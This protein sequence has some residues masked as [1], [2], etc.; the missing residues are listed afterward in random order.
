MMLGVLVVV[1]RRDHISRS[2]LGLG[3]RDITLI[4]SLRVVRSLDLWAWTT[5]W[6]STR[7]VGERGRSPELACIHICASTMLHLFGHLPSSGARRFK[8][9]L[10]IAARAAQ[11]DIP[12]NYSRRSVVRFG[13]AVHSD[14][15][16]SHNL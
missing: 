15:M 14:S 9:D 8:L 12:R 5:R 11:Q 2:G 13:P 7:A 16:R 3:Q 10:L 1:L 4:V 6:L